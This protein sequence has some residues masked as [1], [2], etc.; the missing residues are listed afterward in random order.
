[1]EP[2][3]GE[4]SEELRRYLA[5]D[6]HVILI[7]DSLRERE[8]AKIQRALVALDRWLLQEAEQG[9]PADGPSRSS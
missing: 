2:L 9:A 5:L 8:A 1:V 4:P 6:D 7:T 3:P